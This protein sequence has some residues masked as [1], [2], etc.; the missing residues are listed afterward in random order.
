MRKFIIAIVLPFQIFITAPVSFYYV[1]RAEIN[2]KLIDVFP[3][4]LVLVGVVAALLYLLLLLVSKK[5]IMYMILSGI[6]VGF[7][8]TV[9]VQSQLLIWNFGPLDGRGIPWKEWA[10]HDYFEL[11]LWLVILAFSIYLALRRGVLFN[12]FSILVGALAFLSIA[13]AYVESDEVSTKPGLNNDIFEFHPTNNTIVILLDTFQ[14]DY[15]EKIKNKWPEEVKFLDGFTFYRNT[16]SSYPTTAP[17]L[18]A[19]FTGQVYRN[20]KP[21]SEFIHNSY[22][23]SNLSKKF[24][25]IGYDA[26]IATVSSTVILGSRALTEY[27]NQG[28]RF[29]LKSVA[30]LLDYGLFR[31]LPTY[32]KNEAYRDGDWL[33]SF[34]IKGDYPPDYH[35]VDIRFLEILE[36]KAL[37]NV[38]SKKNGS[39]RFYHFA[40]PHDPWRVNEN[41]K[42]DSL[43]SGEEGY[44]RQARGALLLVRRII[45]RVKSLGIY[46]S[47][48]FIVMSDHGTLSISPVG[49]ASLSDKDFV[50]IEQATQSSALALLLHKKPGA[51]FFGIRTHDAALYNRDLGCLLTFTNLE[52]SAQCDDVM[53]ALKG[54]QRERI[55]YNYNWRHISWGAEYMPPMTEWVTSGHAYDSR[56]WRIGDFRYSKGQK[57]KVLK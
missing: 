50:E 48:E 12:Q 13:V 4:L 11:I 51:E 38:N 57:H 6:L 39:F 10:I 8:L 30:S 16:I 19:I 7:G 2:F 37:V 23:E 21:F 1:N 35:G 52:K 53:N 24:H 5:Q 36:E 43:L 34:I 17:N 54:Q 31:L 56:S 46:E 28:Q 40:I 49:W 26:S 14:S 45:E 32:F 41:L 18:P 25:D 9:W 29:Q 3:V 55:F 44:E 15:F 20:E 47:A 33:L 42:Y 22:A 27:L